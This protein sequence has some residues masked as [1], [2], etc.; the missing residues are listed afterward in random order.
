MDE[1]EEPTAIGSHNHASG[2]RIVVVEIIH[3]REQGLDALIL[4]NVFAAFDKKS[5]LV[6]IV[7]TDGQPFR[8]AQ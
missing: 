2:I 1:E 7:S 3:D 4:P 6:L 8:N 5:V